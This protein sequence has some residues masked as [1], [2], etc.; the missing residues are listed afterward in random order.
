MG[1]RRVTM[2]EKELKRVEVVSEA[3]A[4]GLTNAEAGGLLGISEQQ[5][6]RLKKRYREERGVGREWLILWRWM[7]FRQWA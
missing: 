4:G 6:Q 2:T 1:N 7:Y 3:I 5:V